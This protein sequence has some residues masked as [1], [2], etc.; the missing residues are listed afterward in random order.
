M[1]HLGKWTELV[2]T[3]FTTGFTT[4]AGLYVAAKI[5]GFPIVINIC[6]GVGC[7]P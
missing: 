4:A 7:Y 3:G 2:V 5:L 6:A 1:N